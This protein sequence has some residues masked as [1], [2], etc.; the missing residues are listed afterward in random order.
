[1][2]TDPVMTQGAAS[3]RLQALEGPDRAALARP[4]DEDY[5]DLRPFLLALGQRWRLIAAAT[6]AAVAITAI[7]ANVGL[8]KWYR[9]AAV[10]RPISTPAIESRIAGLLGGLGGGPG[11]GG[12]SGL[13]A[14]MGGG[15]SSDAEEYIA[16][17]RG[18]QFN[19]TLS[20]RHHLSDDLLKSSSGL[21]SMLA[22]RASKDP[23][24][25]IY[26]ILARRFD[27]EYS[28][29]TGN[30]TLNFMAR[31]REDTEKILSYYIDD[32]RDLLRA[33]EVSG[34]SSA[35]DSLKDEANSTPDSLLRSQLYDLVAKQVQ[36]KK[37][38]QVEAD[39]AFRVLDPPAASDKPYRPMVMVDMFLAGML[40]MFVSCL[41]IVVKNTSAPV[42]AEP[43]AKLTA[44][45]LR[46]D[47]H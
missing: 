29:K 2:L 40:A 32:L 21:L 35:I 38:A 43:A 17:L 25:K 34:A 5:V 8:T 7:I 46:S 44:D 31:N 12:L 33:R 41:I 37:I 27:C 26:R 4:P 15:G 11:I 18:F 19:V 20:Q 13:A 28:I 39:F 6:T 16:I 22:F 9:A 3:R 24:W 23:R 36:R 47:R 45:S 10:I 1:M 14:S 42:L 30:I